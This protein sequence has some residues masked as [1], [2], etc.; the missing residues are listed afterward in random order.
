[1]GR[2]VVFGTET[3]CISFVQT[4]KVSGICTQSRLRQLKKWSPEIETLERTLLLW[5]KKN[6]SIISKIDF[7]Q[8]SRIKP[9]YAPNAEH[10]NVRRRDIFFDLHV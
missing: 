7:F 9:I 5:S 10:W 8:N 4:V 2:M 1:M 3:L 6:F